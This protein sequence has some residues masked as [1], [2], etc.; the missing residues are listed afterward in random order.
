MRLTSDSIKPVADAIYAQGYAVVQTLLD[1]HVVSALADECCNADLHATAVGHG[2]SR[3]ERSDIRGDRTRWL[4]AS[5][6]SPAQ[7]AYFD[8]MEALRIGLNR[9]LMLGLDEL[10]SHFALYAPGKRYA[11]HRD[12]FRDDDTR[13]LSSV[14]YL[15]HDWRESDGGAL[16]LYLADRHLDIY[17]SAAKLVLFLSA[18]FD[19][20]VLPATRDRLSIAGWFRRRA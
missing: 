5:D 13:V 14:L 20:E 18:D 7:R 8:A 1:A 3:I 16:R 2:D 10:E 4:E 9:A 17:P 11:R 19:H 12:R 15:N 6:A